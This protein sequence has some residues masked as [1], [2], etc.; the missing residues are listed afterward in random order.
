[1]Y[2]RGRILIVDDTPH[3]LRLI[4]NLLKTRG[5]QVRAATNGNMALSAV[6]SVLPELILLDIRMP[7]LDGFE[8]CQRLKS[9]PETCDIPV[10][11]LSALDDIGDK[12]KA[13]EAGGIDYITKPFHVA[14]VLVRVETHLNLRRLQQRLAQQ[15]ERLQ[16]EVSD[17][18]T[19][20]A[21][22]QAANQELY[23]LA[24]LDGLTQVANRRRF[25]ECLDQEWRRMAREQQPLSLILCDI[26]FFKDYND[27]YG[28]IAGD[29][30]LRQVASVLGK[31]VKRPSDLVARYGG[32]EFI[33]TL[34]NT[35]L[36]GAVQVT[37]EIQTGIKDLHLIHAGSPNQNLTLSFGVV[38]VL[39]AVTE[40][41]IQMMLAAERCSMKQRPWGAIAWQP[42]S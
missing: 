38:T 8:V 41:P 32:E 19:A 7:E 24:N 42:P 33:I 16:Q 13:F 14:E 20:E 5:Y 30:C 22:L 11:F 2:D 36:S 29:E 12:L 27:T 39:P 10:I 6:H 23:R 34:P 35:P 15:N 37:T 25:D 4:A 40:S 31:T 17:R 28:H 26:D 3:N 21:A 9:N 18:L 1:M